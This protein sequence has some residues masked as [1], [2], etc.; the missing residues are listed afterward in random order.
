VI[1][2]QGSGTPLLLIPGS[3]GRWEYMRPAIDALSAAAF[4]VITFPLCGEPASG[5]GFDRPRV[6]DNDVAQAASALDRCGVDRAFVCGISYGGIVALAFAAAHP[7]RT[8]ALVL[9]STPGPMWR[10]RAR[11]QI[12]ARKPRLFGPIF[13][14]EAPWRLRAELAAAFPNWAARSRFALAQL[15]LFVTAPVSLA[16]IAGR[17]A[18]ISGIDVAPTCARVVAPTLV[19][20]GEPRLDHVVPVDGSSGYLNLIR[21]ARAV[22]LERTGHL[23]ALTRPDAFAAAVRAFAATAERESLRSSPRASDDDAA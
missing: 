18:M 20:T 10:L 23:G 15:Q 12:Y 22:V 1:F 17:A 14:A 8:A 5:A 19:V 2:E 6:V 16:R 9:T 21:G 7:D 13:L 4:R 3:Q 11:H